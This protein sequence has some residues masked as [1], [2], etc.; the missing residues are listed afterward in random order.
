MHCFLTER[1]ETPVGPMVL[2]AKDGVVLLFEFEGTPG[3]VERQMRARFG[4]VELQ[5][6]TNPFGISDQIRDYFAGDIRALDTLLTDGGGTEFERQVWA[7]LRQIPAGTTVSY[8]HIAR[9]L[10]DIQ[11]SRAVGTANGKNPIAIIVPCHR[12]IGADGS[13]TG[14]GG[15]IKNKEWLLRHEGALLL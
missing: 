15:G 6:A 13:M 14:Y 4:D 10:G 11:H 12:V 9:K 1:L 3:R 7:E 2:V 5:A 8:G